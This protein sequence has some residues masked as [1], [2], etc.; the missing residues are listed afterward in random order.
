M[1]ISST[2]FSTYYLNLYSKLNA[3]RNSQ[4]SSSPVLNAVSESYK[5]ALSDLGTLKSS[6]ATFQTSARTLTGSSLNLFTASSSAST[7]L[8]RKGVGHKNL[9][10]FV[11]H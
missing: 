1:S 9:S 11:G 5:V 7:V 6:L 3:A 4:Y 2:A 8:V 10:R